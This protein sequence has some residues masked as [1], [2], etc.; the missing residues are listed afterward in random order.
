M[1]EG[2]I[3]KLKLELLNKVKYYFLIQALSPFEKLIY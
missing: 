3:K 2:L 1:V